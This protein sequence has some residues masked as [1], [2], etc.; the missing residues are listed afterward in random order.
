[1]LGR[2]SIRRPVTISP[3]TRRLSSMSRYSRSR[4]GSSL[5]SHMN[6]D[7]WPAPS[8][9]SAPS[10]TGMLN[11]PKL[12]VVISPTEYVRPCQ[13]P[14]GQ[15][16]RRESQL[17]GSL[18]DPF[19]GLRA[20]L[21]LPVQR[22]GRGPD[23]HPRKRGDLPDRHPPSRRLRQRA[24]RGPAHRVGRR[25]CGGRLRLTGKGLLRVSCPG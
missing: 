3:S 11:R 20:E 17:A 23:R 7:I 13:Q 24:E 10:M 8:A 9:S 19:P 22:L 12:S 21:P 15:H 4:T 18:R 2:G 5:V 16:V 25:R 14:T 1:M 6:T